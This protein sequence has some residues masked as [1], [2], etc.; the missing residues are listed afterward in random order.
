MKLE[1]GESP[2]YSITGA[3]PARI[4][5]I[6]QPLMATLLAEHQEHPPLLDDATIDNLMKLDYCQNTLGIKI[7]YPILRRVEDGKEISGRFGRAKARYYT[8]KYA[9]KF[10]VCNHWQK[11]DHRANAESLRQF[12][13]DIARNNPDDHPGIPALNNHI[14]ALS[15]YAKS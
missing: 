1:I 4:Q 10:Y 15:D 2:C 5:L 14:K 11:K 13:L 9:G 6:V 8:K 3:T 12:A 7:I